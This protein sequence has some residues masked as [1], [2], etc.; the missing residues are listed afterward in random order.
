[1]GN[2][3]MVARIFKKSLYRFLLGRRVF[4][5]IVGY[6]CQGGYLFRYRHLGVDKGLKTIYNFASAVF[7]RTYLGYSAIFGGEPR[8]FNIEYNKGSVLERNVIL[9]IIFKNR[10]RGIIYKIALH[11]IDGLDI[12]IFFTCL[13]NFGKSLQVSVVGYSK[14]RHT[15]FQGST[16]NILRI[17]KRIK[18][19][20][21]CVHM[22]LD[23][24]RWMVIL[25]VY[26]FYRRYVF[27]LYNDFI[28]EFIISRLSLNDKARLLSGHLQS[29]ILIQGKT[30][31]NR[32]IE[33]G[34]VKLIIYLVS[35]I[36]LLG[37]YIK[38]S[39]YETNDISVCNLS[40][41]NK[42]VYSALTVY[43]NRICYIKLH[44]ARLYYIFIV[45]V[46]KHLIRIF[47]R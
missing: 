14:R 26:G 19:G 24:R 28:V 18:C 37:F 9:L 11:S 42:I 22:Q 39:A 45:P 29:V 33:I 17:R 16:D 31:N 23:T 30:N 34:H 47:Q 46:I 3:H 27:T 21:N 6:T 41:R 20:H 43:C 38:H 4:N 15:P 13:H 10:T 2:K 36:I 1:M 44:S 35:V 40:Y 32:G 12:F 8:C 7:E 25:S 5:H